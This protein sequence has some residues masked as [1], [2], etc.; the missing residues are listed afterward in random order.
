[1]KKIFYTIE[2]SGNRYELNVEEHGEEEIPS[3]II[4]DR[5]GKIFEC[6]GHRTWSSLINFTH[7]LKI[8][9]TSWGSD[10]GN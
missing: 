7:D 10:L 9:I 1:M 2:N 5:M 6:D 4:E 3:S 8:E